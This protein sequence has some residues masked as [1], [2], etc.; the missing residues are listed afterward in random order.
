MMVP[1]FAAGAG[2][3]DLNLV[4]WKW[5]GMLDLV[6]DEGGWPDP[7][8]WSGSPHGLRLLPAPSRQGSGATCHN[9]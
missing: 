5:E 9:M 6:D 7:P 4:L 1:S 2:E 8:L 3:E